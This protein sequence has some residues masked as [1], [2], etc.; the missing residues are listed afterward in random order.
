MSYGNRQARFHLKLKIVYCSALGLFFLCSSGLLLTLVGFTIPAIAALLVLLFFN[1]AGFITWQRHFIPDRRFKLITYFFLMQPFY[2]FLGAGLLSIVLFP[3]LLFL[4]WVFPH[5]HTLALESLALIVIAAY[6]VS[7]RPKWVQSNR[8]IIRSE[9]IPAAF[10]G[11]KLLHITDLHMGSMLSRRVYRNWLAKINQEE[12]DLIVITGDFLT[13]GNA[14]I[15]Y[16][17]KWLTTLAYKDGV[18][19]STGNHEQFIDLEVLKKSL[20]KNKVFLIDNQKF[21]L[22]RGDAQID[23]IAIRGMVDAMA[24]NIA[25]LNAVLAQGVQYPLILLSHD[26]SLFDYAAQKNILLTLSGHTHGGQLALP[27]FPRINLAGKYRYSSGHYQINQSH[28]IVNRGLGLINLP[29]RLGAAPE[30]QCITLSAV[31]PSTREI[32]T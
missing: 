15:A 13:F 1:L 8:T 2:I 29:L 22:K 18:V 17:N 26:G 19:L 7:I 16:F 21:T 14:Y 11:Y 31:Q 32:L 12:A 5:I 23:V 4:Y 6:S 10:S 28:L 25:D 9:S 24:A 3:I 30:L 27:F 20:P